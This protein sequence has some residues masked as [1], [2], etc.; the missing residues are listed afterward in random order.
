MKKIIGFLFL[1]PLLFWIG[2]QKEGSGS[3]FK[4][5]KENAT[6]SIEIKNFNAI[7]L[8]D[9]I[10][11]DVRFGNNY[12]VELTGPKN[13]LEYCNI[14]IQGNTLVA[15]N[16]TKCYVTKGYDFSF[17]LKV[18]LPKLDS[19][20]TDGYGNI[21]FIDTLNQPTFKL[22]NFGTAGVY[23]L[24]LNTSTAKIAHHLGSADISVYGSSN[25]GEL[26]LGSNGRIDASKLFTNQAFVNHDGDGNIYI[27]T[28][29]YL[30]Y[31]LTSYGDLYAYGNP[32]IIE[33]SRSGKGNFFEP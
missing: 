3:C 29:E 16:F 11:L 8:Y 21:D 25:I 27:Y 26:F 10:N 32:K 24:L 9:D 17:N 31:S 5:A 6:K 1:V 23:S 22:E 19:I 28:S 20:Y 30:S 13:L 4:G 12:E 33:G 15:E 18:T 2:C 7:A 14:E